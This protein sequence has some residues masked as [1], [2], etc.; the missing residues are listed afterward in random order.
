MPS[1]LR[2][3]PPIGGTSYALQTGVVASCPAS[4]QD[5]LEIIS[6]IFLAFAGLTLLGLRRTGRERPPRRTS[7]PSDRYAGLAVP[8][9]PAANVLDAIMAADKDFNVQ[10]FIVGAESAYERIVTAY[11]KGD[12]RELT[13]LL[14]PTVYEGFDAVIREREA[15]GETAETHFLSIDATDITAAEFHGK[16]VHITVRFVAEFVSTTRDRNGTIIDGSADHIA[17][18]TDVWTF[19]RNVTARDPNWKLA[20]TETAA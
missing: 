1:T 13:N 9:S 3:L 16:V 11:A 6:I 2:L 18:V 14:A 15:R 19:A 17:S 7:E 12:R 4:K 8:G 10:Y 20:A 5:V